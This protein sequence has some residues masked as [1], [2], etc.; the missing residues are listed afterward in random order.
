MGIVQDHLRIYSNA[1]NTS[2]LIPQ[3][4][5]LCV[6]EII[7]LSCSTKKQQC[8]QALWGFSFQ[9]VSPLLVFVLSNTS[10]AF[11]NKQLTDQRLDFLQNFPETS[12][13]FKPLVGTDER[14]QTSGRRRRR[15]RRREKN[16][17][18][19]KMEEEN[20]AGSWRGKQRRGGIHF[21]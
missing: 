7:F 16:T 6:S 13:G 9:N 18:I 1:G 2:R 14:R 12:I 17:I 11:M 19:S 15:K 3:N 10:A 20:E 5:R 8:Q 21:V 4:N